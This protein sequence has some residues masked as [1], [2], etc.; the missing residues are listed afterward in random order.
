MTLGLLR[1][2]ESTAW[3]AA[4]FDTSPPAAPGDGGEACTATAV[5][6]VTSATVN[7]PA[8]VANR[9]ETFKGAL[10]SATPVPPGDGRWDGPEPTGTR[11]CRSVWMDRVRAEL[12]GQPSGSTCSDALTITWG[13]TLRQGS[14][15]LNEPLLAPCNAR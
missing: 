11:T 2:K 5:P 3:A 10:F 15:P 6:A 4:A 13:C 8:A 12:P 9:G 14:M 1:T 7:T